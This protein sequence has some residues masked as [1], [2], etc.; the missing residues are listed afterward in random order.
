M[1]IAWFPN[2]IAQ[3]GHVV[4]EAMITA[5]RARGHGIVTNSLD[6]DAAVIWSM[7]WAGRMRGNQD[8]FQHYRARNQP[9]IVLEVGCLRRGVLWKVGVNGVSSWQC[10]ATAGGPARSSL[11]GMTLQPWQQ[12]RGRDIMICLQRTQSQ[13]W[14]GMPDQQQWISDVVREVR[15][16]TDRPIVVRPHPRQRLRFELPDCE[17]QTPLLC[18][19]TYDDFDFDAALKRAWAVINFNSHPGTQSVIQGIPAFVDQS[20]MAA[21]V[22]NLDL[23]K[24]ED[25]RMPDR[26]AWFENLMWTEYSL[27]EIRRGMPLDRLVLA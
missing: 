22:A 19:G 23:V 11:L 4:I 6:A 3:N 7:L 21:P 1:D 27:D 8:I 15:R 12:H 2:N 10:L 9:V 13:Q 18:T 17:I 25:P 24:I 14:H 16:H 20:S 26:E 5:L